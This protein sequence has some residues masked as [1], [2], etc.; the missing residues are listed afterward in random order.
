MQINVA[1]GGG[2]PAAASLTRSAQVQMQ[3]SGSSSAA[4]HAPTEPV[5]DVTVALSPV[6]GATLEAQDSGRDEGRDPGRDPGRETGDNVL[7]PPGLR[8]AMAED[9]RSGEARADS[10]Q[11]APQA[12]RAAAAADDQRRPGPQ[13]ELTPEE[14]AVVDELRKRDAEVRAHEMAHVA[15]AGG[16]AGAPSFSY[17]TGPDGKRYAVGGSVSIDTS[18][19]ADPEDTIAKA[20][21]IR[22]AALAP[23]DPSGQDRAVAAKASQMEASARAALAAEKRQEQDARAEEAQQRME[24]ATAVDPQRPGAPPPIEAPR[25][26]D[27]PPL[28]DAGPPVA[29]GIAVMATPENR[30]RLAGFSGGTAAE[31][32]LYT[33]P[34][35][36]I[37]QRYLA[38][39][40]ARVA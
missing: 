34:E 32:Q 9:A 26:V 29:G 11:P 3:V 4:L 10:A 8:A 5:P 16:L 37:E 13:A 27:L 15:A 21:R 14:Q 19:G 24:Q 22:A 30:V 1:I 25:A 2:I 33:P 31:A 38:A 12:P 39:S 23:A 40:R 17:Q 28:P 18:G 20:Q 36:A 7:S 6:A 35:R